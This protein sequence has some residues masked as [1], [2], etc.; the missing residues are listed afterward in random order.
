MTAQSDDGETGVYPTEA[1]ARPDGM[2]PVELASG[3]TLYHADTER[4]ARMTH[5]IVDTDVPGLVYAVAS[6]TEGLQVEALDYRAELEQYTGVRPA[7]VSGLRQVR[8]VRSFLDELH[9]RPLDPVYSTLT[10]VERELYVVAVYDD[11]AADMVTN[12]HGNRAAGRGADRLQ[13]K[14]HYSPEWLDW[15]KLDGAPM[16]QESFGDAIEE[17]LHTVREPAQ[18]ELLEVIDNLRVTSSG[19]AES[20]INRANGSMV[21]ELHDDQQV[22]AGRLTVPETITFAVPV[23]DGASTYYQ[24]QAWLRVRVDRGQVRLHV[25]LK[26]YRQI[27]LAAWRD[28]LADISAALPQEHSAATGDQEA[29]STPVFRILEA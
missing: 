16:G 19:H 23:Y 9:R 25:K 12:Q 17:R 15:L 21:I 8:T 7:Y 27:L 14:L 24:F 3:G 28:V 10:A 29:A 4:M 5:T 1:Q 13:L 22:S 26:P 6:G 11:H 2:E 20:K 18:A